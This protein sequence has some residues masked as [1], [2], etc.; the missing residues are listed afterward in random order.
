MT[1]RISRKQIKQDEFV[2]TAVDFGHWL[3]QHWK[4]VAGGALAVLLLAVAIAGGLAWSRHRAERLRVQLAA[5]IDDYR[6]FEKAGSEDADGAA[7]LAQ[8]FTELEG[9]AGQP[10]R[11]VAAFYRGAILFN[12]GR[13]DE[14]REPLARV[15]A[16]TTP[17]DTLGATARLMLARAEAA[18]GRHEEAQKELQALLDAP[19]AAVPP[20]EVLFELGR[21]EQR[22]GRAD[23]ARRTWQRVVDDYPQGTAAA[24]ARK[25]LR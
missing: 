16:G 5:A 22:A 24:E 4:P 7:A 18:V 12:L 13:A 21:V 10:T 2:E 8:R 9:S 19:E 25:L 6:R 15:V 17:E 1:Q 23:D 20:D 11:H 14:A 3:E